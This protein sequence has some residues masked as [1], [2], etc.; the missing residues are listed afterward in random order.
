[1]FKRIK[2]NIYV[3]KAIDF[4]LN[5]LIIIFSFV[6]LVSVYTSLQT[7]VLGHKYANFFGYTSFEVQTGSMEKA[8][9][10]GDLII[11]KLTDE[12]KINDIITYEFK[13][14]YITHR[15]VEVYNNKYITKGDANNTKDKPIDKKQIIGKVEYVAAN[16]GIIRKVLFNPA[17][18]ASFMLTL[19]LFNMVIKKNKSESERTNKEKVF[20]IF[21][22]NMVWLVNRIKNLFNRRK[23]VE[24]NINIVT[25]NIADTLKE[26]EKE[27]T[28]IDESVENELEKTMLYRVIPVDSTEIDDTFLE[29]AKNELKEAELEAKRKAKMIEEEPEED[30]IEEDDSLTKINLEL[31]KEKKGIKKSKNVIET[32]MLIKKEELSEILNIFT[33]DLKKQTGFAT[34][35]NLFIN[36][37]IETKYYNLNREQNTGNSG[38]SIANKIK[39]VLIE[40]G[41]KTIDKYQGKN[42]KHTDIVDRHVNSLTLIADLENAR[43]S[44]KEIKA[45]E[46]FYRK[47]I[48]EHYKDLD[49]DRI[50]EITDGIIKIQRNYNNMIEYLLKKFQTNMF[51]LTF[52]KI[53]NVKNM[54]GLKLE[55]NISFSKV[56]SDYIIDKVYNEG[57]I[58]EDKMIVLLNLLSIQLIRDMTSS[59]NNRRYVLYIPQSLY[60]KNN[61]LDKVLKMIDDSY[62]KE[63]VII[64]VKFEE[65]VKNKKHIK[66]VRKLGYR[67]AL[68][69]DKEIVISDRNRP[70]IYIADYIFVN[71]KAEGIE[72]TI[73]YMPEEIVKYIIYDN[74]A[75]KIGDVGSD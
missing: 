49:E 1:M 26:E 66:E 28:I 70:N 52:N 24:E 46:E 57:I 43:D 63:N 9:S 44:I 48:G 29:I 16:F 65:L 50:E 64:L 61:K 35:R 59:N 69:F 7:R 6:L 19:F 53:T 3:E 11:V 51:D 20:Y 32:V 55:H 72:K 60:A 73:S 30:T 45:R 54:Y 10:A 41:S 62:A 68:F 13:G 21:F 39:S 56:Y 75:N 25:S 37:Y 4:L 74:V 5:I 17:V 34:V 67:F 8:I 40:V 27:Q 23:I 47:K 36:T 58:A 38:R 31:L 42:K 18:L 2:N 15:I 22:K 14:Q 71:K 12:V 33:E